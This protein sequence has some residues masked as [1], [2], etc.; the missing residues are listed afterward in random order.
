MTISLIFILLLLTSCTTRHEETP[1][2]ATP[3]ITATS[4]QGESADGTEIVLPT[5]GEAPIFPYPEPGTGS[6]Q[7]VGQESAYP[8]PY[9][10]GAGQSFPEAYP[11]PDQQPVIPTPV[12]ET[13]TSVERLPDGSYPP[14]P[15]PENPWR[16]R[17]TGSDGESTSD[18]QLTAEPSSPVL[19]TSPTSRTDGP[20]QTPTPLSPIPTLAP[21]TQTLPPPT[22]TPL[23]PTPTPLPTRIPVSSRIVATDPGTVELDSGMPQLIEFF[24]YWDGYSKSCLL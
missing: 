19:T 20:T 9:P 6:D 18:P 15:T 17:P 11:G 1:L 14:P 3:T 16:P 24:A 23:P 5:Q 7:P 2:P 4:T 13:P 10:G 8:D 21:P 22:P 12:L